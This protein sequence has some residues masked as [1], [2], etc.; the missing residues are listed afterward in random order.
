MSEGSRLFRKYDL[1]SR[2]QEI[3]LPSSGRYM[4]QILSQEN[5]RRPPL[6]RKETNT[7]KPRVAEIDVKIS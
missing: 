7:L 5:V 1:R 4:L 2:E 3:T 6:F